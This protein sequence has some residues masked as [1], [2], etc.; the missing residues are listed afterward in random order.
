MPPNGFVT[1]RAVQIGCGPVGFRAEISRQCRAALT[2]T[3]LTD[4]AV[5]VL[6]VEA[7]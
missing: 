5:D 3:D 2:F 7:V 1:F 4:D 6:R